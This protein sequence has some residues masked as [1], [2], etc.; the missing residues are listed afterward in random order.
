MARKK[1]PDAGNLQRIGETQL[2]TIN[3]LWNDFIGSVLQVLNAIR[4]LFNLGSQ[5]DAAAVYY[6][7]KNFAGTAAGQSVLGQSSSFDINEIPIDPNFPG[8]QGYPDRF[9][10][11][12][13]FELGGEFFSYY[14]FSNY[15]P[16]SRSLSLSVAEYIRDHVPNYPRLGEM[17][18]DNPDEPIAIMLRDI[19]RRY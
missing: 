8:A 5:A 9:R 13:S 3:R 18:S 1:S 2:G 19:R 17:L 6:A 14:E 16:T 4:S 7:A 12:V 11:L 15:V 10:Y